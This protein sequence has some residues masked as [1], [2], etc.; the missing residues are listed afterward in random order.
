MTKP[1][2]LPAALI[3][4][5]MLATPAMARESHV[6]SRHLAV[7]TDACTTPKAQYIGERDGFCG[8]E[9]RDVWGHWGT[10]YGPL[11]PSIP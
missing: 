9:G 2:F 5:A 11:V 8:Y 7:N 1:K 3:A 10:Y 6:G 4:A